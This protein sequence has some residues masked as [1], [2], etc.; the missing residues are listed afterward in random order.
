[1]QGPTGVN[2]PLRYR[3]KKCPAFSL[4][5]RAIFLHLFLPCFS[6]SSIFWVAVASSFAEC[7]D[8]LLRHTSRNLTSNS[9]QFVLNRALRSGRF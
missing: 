7:I 6:H 2:A 1:M 3:I 4:S 8:R 9:A 5:L